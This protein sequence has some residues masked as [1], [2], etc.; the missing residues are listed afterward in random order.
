MS[1]RLTK[2][3][4]YPSEYAHQSV[5]YRW[6]GEK[7]PPRKGEFYLS[8][9]R[10]VAYRAGGDLSYAYHIAEPVPGSENLCPQCHG[11]GKRNP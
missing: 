10:I 6:N 4:T 1:E 7:R 11:T 8:G 3:G 5:R 9:S 2:W